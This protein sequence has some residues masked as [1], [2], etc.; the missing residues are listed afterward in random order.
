MSLRLFHWKTGETRDDHG[1]TRHLESL[2]ELLVGETCLCALQLLHTI[3]LRH[4]LAGILSVAVGLASNRLQ[5]LRVGPLLGL[6]RPLIFC[7][8]YGV[9]KL[10]TGKVGQCFADLLEIT[11]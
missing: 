4:G 5:V 6:H 1:R 8:N 10:N 3:V 9:F 2:R 7:A 11:L